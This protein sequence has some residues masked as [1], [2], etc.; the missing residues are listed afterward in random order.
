MH[1]VLEKTKGSVR[2]DVRLKSDEVL[3][4]KLSVERAKPLKPEELSLISVLGRQ[5]GRILQ[6]ITQ[7]ER[8]TDFQKMEDGMRRAMAVVSHQFRNELTPLDIVLTRYR[9][10]ADKSAVVSTAIA[11]VNADFLAD[12][13]LLH[14]VIDRMPDFLGTIHP[15]YASFDLLE[16]ISAKLGRHDMAHEVTSADPRV[17]V[18]GDRIHLG[19]VLNELLDNTR[20]MWHRPNERPKVRVTVSPFVRSEK[21]FVRL[22]YE[23]FG[24]GI[25]EEIREHRIFEPMYSYRPGRAPGTGI[26]L[27]YARR[28]IAAHGGEIRTEAS[29]TGARFVLEIP[30]FGEGSRQ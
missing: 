17:P 16:E 28:V 2:V 24:P 11:P 22:V 10:A 23:D 3:F 12:L 14:S 26:G 27:D 1:P 7:T 20:A 21:P 13:Q 5:S 6:S 9:R 18:E 8:I 25:P 15:R 29:A 4:G 19:S 30:Q